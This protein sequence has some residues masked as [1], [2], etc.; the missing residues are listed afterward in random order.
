[1]TAVRHALLF[2]DYYRFYLQDAATSAPTVRDPSAA[3]WGVAATAHRIAVSTARNDLVETILRRHPGPPPLVTEAEHIVEADLEVPTGVLAIHGRTEP[4][5]DLPVPP[6]RYR[7]RVSY[8]PSDPP[9][10]ADLDVSGAH[11]SYV[12]EMWPSPDPAPLAVVR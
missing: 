9:P 3:G 8:Q 10:G 7:V 4:G 2:A 12:V 1:V 6:G 11:F 5:N